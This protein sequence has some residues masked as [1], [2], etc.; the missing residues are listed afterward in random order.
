MAARYIFP[1]SQKKKKEAAPQKEAGGD[2]KHV[3]CV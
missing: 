3:Y 1:D 2:A